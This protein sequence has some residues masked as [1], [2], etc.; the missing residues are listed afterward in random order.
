MPTEIERKFLLK[1]D[2]WRFD[3]KGTARQGLTLTQG[4]LAN[5]PRCS[6]R[7][8][9]SA[10]QAFLTLKGKSNTASGM[11]RSE[12]EYEIPLADGTRILSEMAESRL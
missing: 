1:N 8:R 3:E 6:V 7:L 12:Y 10:A 5:T 2:S 11:S 4:Y 9:L